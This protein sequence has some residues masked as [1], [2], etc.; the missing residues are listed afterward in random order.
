MAGSEKITITVTGKGGHAGMPHKA[1]DSV[2]VASHLVVALQTV[3]SRSVDPQQAAVLS[4]G[5]IQGGSRHN[6]LAEVT[7]LTGTIRIFNQIAGDVIHKRISAITNGVGIAFGAKIDI[8]YGDIVYPPVINNSEECFEAVKSAAEQV[9]PDGF[10]VWEP[11]NAAEDFSGFLLKRPGNF[12]FLGVGPQDLEKAT[13]HHKPDFW[14]DER[15]LISGVQTWVNLAAL[16][17]GAIEVQI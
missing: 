12:W 14:I 13:S 5:M 9:L 3:I 4:I 11:I 10:S 15:S 6:I 7:T 8:E 2:V 16:R 17:V 1:I